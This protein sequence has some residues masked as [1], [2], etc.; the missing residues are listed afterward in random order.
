ML[1][2]EQRARLS[3]QAVFPKEEN[4]ALRVLHQFG[5]QDKKAKFPSMFIIN[6]RQRI[7]QET[8]ELN[9]DKIDKALHYGCLLAANFFSDLPEPDGTIYMSDRVRV[10]DASPECDGLKPRKSQ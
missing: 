2:A 3:Q 1:S 6:P 7:F 5:P 8:F 9:K 4:M 10:A